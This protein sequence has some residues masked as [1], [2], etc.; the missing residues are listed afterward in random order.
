MVWNRK[1]PNCK[2]VAMKFTGNDI[3]VLIKDM[4]FEQMKFTVSNDTLNIEKTM[5]GSPCPVKSKGVY[6]YEIKE[7]KIFSDKC[8]SRQYNRT[9]ADLR[10]QHLKIKNFL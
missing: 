8:D 1:C 2:N 9:V 10:K 6:K 5:G 4:V 3:K 7:D